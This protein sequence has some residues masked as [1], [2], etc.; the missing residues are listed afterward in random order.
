MFPVGGGSFI[1]VADVGLYVLCDA[2]WVAK[3]LCQCQ[4]WKTYI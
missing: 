3:Y 4:C 2:F 1:L